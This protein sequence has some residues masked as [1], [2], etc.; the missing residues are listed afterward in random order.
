MKSWILNLLEPSGPETGI[1]LLLQC[2][3]LEELELSVTPM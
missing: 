3:I 1:A 2:H